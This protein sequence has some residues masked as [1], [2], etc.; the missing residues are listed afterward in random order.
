ME[1][2]GNYVCVNSKV[3]EMA[4]E[5]VGSMVSKLEIELLTHWSANWPLG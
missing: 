4:Y 3:K 5:L 2:Q 1:N